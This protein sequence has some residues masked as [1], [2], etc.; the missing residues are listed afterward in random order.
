MKYQSST[1]MLLRFGCYSNLFFQFFFFWRW[2]QGWDYCWR[3]IEQLGE[4]LVFGV[5]VCRGGGLRGR[6]RGR[7]NS[8]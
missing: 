3:D 4:G 7:G 2:R 8:N 5:F 6:G 1:S